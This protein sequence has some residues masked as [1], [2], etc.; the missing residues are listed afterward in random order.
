MPGRQP[1]TDFRGQPET[2]FRGTGRG[3]RKKGKTTLS[4]ARRKRGDSCAGR[5]GCSHAGPETDR[6]ACRTRGGAVRAVLVRLPPQSRQ[7]GGAEGLAADR[8]RR[9]TDR[10]HLP[11]P[12][13]RQGVGAMAARRGALHSLS[14]HL[15]APGGMGGPAHRG[16]RPAS[17]RG[18]Q[19]A[20]TGDDYQPRGSVRRQAWSSG[21]FSRR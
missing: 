18:R 16:S 21:P 9:R 10:A 1:E 4:S 6:G 8:S 7:G 17:G 15:A 11:G 19:R 13:R 5:S 3:N 2:H 14:R 20:G 12:G